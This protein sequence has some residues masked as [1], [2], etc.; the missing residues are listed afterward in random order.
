MEWKWAVLSWQVWRRTTGWRCRMRSCR[1]SAASTASACRGRAGSIATDGIRRCGWCTSRRGWSGR[2]PS[3]GRSCRIGRR[4]CSGCAGRSRWS[5][6]GRWRSMGMSR[7]SNCSGFCR[8]LCGRPRCA[9]GIGSARSIGSS[10]TGCS[11]CWT[12]SK[13]GMRVWRTRRRRLGVRPI[14]WCGWRGVS[15]SCCAESMRCGSC[16]GLVRCGRS[17]GGPG[18]GLKLSNRRVMRLRCTMRSW[19]S[20]DRGSILPSG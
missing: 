10:G 6:G 3:V 17:C 12:S 9:R 20:T 4:R 15:R 14:S 7:R 13:R 5:Y 19:R 16:G 8:V 2:P 1:H 11:I 18:C